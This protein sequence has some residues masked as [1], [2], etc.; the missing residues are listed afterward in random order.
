VGINGLAIL[1]GNPAVRVGP[2]ALR[3]QVALSLLLSEWQDCN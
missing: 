1:F 3:P 2:V